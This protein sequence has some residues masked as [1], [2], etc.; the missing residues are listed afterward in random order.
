MSHQCSRNPFYGDIKK[1]H[2]ELTSRCN[3]ACPQC[4]RNYSGGSTRVNIVETELTLLD[5]KRLLPP[6]FVYGLDL[7]LVNGNYGDGAV[8]SETLEI[9]EYFRMQ[10]RRL[11]LMLFSNGSIRSTDWWERLGATVDEVHW[12]IDGLA[13]TNHIY[14]RKTDFE[15]I[16]ANAAAF[17]RSG[18]K[19]VW[20]FN[21]FRHNEHQV[22]EARAMSQ[23]LGFSNFVV[24]K[25]SRFQSHG[26]LLLK[27]PVLSS[28]G[29]VE[30]Y[31]E[32]PK[33]KAYVNKVYENLETT[34]NSQPSHEAETEHYER[35][36]L[37]G[38]RTA[39]V[40]PDE[41]K[42]IL[43]NT[44]IDCVAQK[45]KSVFINALG[46]VFPCC[47]VGASS[48]VY[49]PGVGQIKKMLQNLPSGVD[50]LCA[51]HRPVK[52][53][54][55]NN[56]FQSIQKSWG[57]GNVEPTMVCARQCRKGMGTQDNQIE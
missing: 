52:E 14:R 9:F 15:K 20:V 10:N 33:N 21:V 57:G 8:A 16:M 36:I 43:R 2:L 31:L 12:G 42:E 5:I 41:L 32:I 51:M 47:W 40:L 28:S 54:V 35:E 44:K 23:K 27:S 6:S 56:F 30:Y 19:S 39:P 34:E 22:E 4:L 29:E 7:L 48:P 49:D 24:R 1:V 18:K 25:T 55:E 11:H 13:D 45:E 26:K 53:I 17:N 46:Q 3:A 50:D 38:K 37:E